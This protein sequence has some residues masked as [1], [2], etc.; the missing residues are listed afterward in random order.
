MTSNEVRVTPPTEKQVRAAQ[1]I[2]QNLG[3]PLPAERSKSAY[4]RFIKENQEKSFAVSADTPI[5]DYD[6]IAIFD[7][8]YGEDFFY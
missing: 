3:I 2:S 5:T 7:G 1:I 8:M 4:W 6:Y